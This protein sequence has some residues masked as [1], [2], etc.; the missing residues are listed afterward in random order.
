LLD[1]QLSWPL[2]ISLA[3]HVALLL[4]VALLPMETMSASEPIYVTLTGEDEAISVKTPV[5]EE[6]RPAA[7][8]R[9]TPRK[10]EPR[11]SMPPRGLTV[12]PAPLPAR[13]ERPDPG[14]MIDL[15][16]DDKTARDSVE[17][18][19][20][21]R[22]DSDT[23][24]DVLPVDGSRPTRTSEPV[25]SAGRPGGNRIS[26]GQGIRRRITYNPG[27]P[28]LPERYRREGIPFSAEIR[29]TVTPEGLVSAT[30]V[31]KS[32][33]WPEVD[34]ILESNARQYRFAPVLEQR[35][36][37]GMYRFQFQLK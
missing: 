10:P 28:S 27:D 25:V 31:V 16:R 2:R 15:P 23:A 34:R 29:I 26:F 24:D 9:K 7:A 8:P 35:D 30:S 13:N 17:S 21:T 4:I 32:S 19:D 11:K 18:R 22:D 5:E 12:E 3:I 1:R 36:M 6:G 37:E 33:G 14:E 20:D